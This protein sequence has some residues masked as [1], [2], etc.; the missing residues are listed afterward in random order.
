MSETAQPTRCGMTTVTRAVSHRTEPPNIPLV[1]RKGEVFLLHAA[2]RRRESLLVT[3]P[4]GSGK[5]AL[6]HKVLSELPPA[7]ARRCFY[8]SAVDGVQPLLRSVIQRLY[9]SDD[10][11]LRRQLHL[12][13]IRNSTFKSWLK[14][15]PTSRLKGAVYRSMEKGNYW[16]FLDHLPHL[17]HAEATIVRELVWMR[18]TPVFLLARG[19]TEDDI[20]GVASIYCGN[21]QQV[22]LSSLPAQPARE[23]L[24]HCIQEMGL[25]TLDLGGFR[26]EVLKL[27]G[28]VPG[29]IV[30]MCQLAQAPKYLSGLRPKT[31]LI[32]IDCLMR[33]PVSDGHTVARTT[34]RYRS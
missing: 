16:L 15:Q 30:K 17:T 1:D 3:G 8:L 32:H 9:E 27:S 31:K 6:I 26:E 24:E 10:I 11:T 29:I 4:A 13:G 18:K 20:G 21:Q 2:I 23:L 25:E 12:E 5:T 22:S 7:I 28:L 33:G 14:R 19:A 34:I